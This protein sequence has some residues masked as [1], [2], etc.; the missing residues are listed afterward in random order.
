[1]I[2]NGP[3]EAAGPMRREGPVIRMRPTN[4]WAGC[5]A[6]ARPYACGLALIETHGAATATGFCQ[7]CPVREA[8]LAGALA[9]REPWGVW[10]GELISN[11]KILAN[12]RKRGRPPKARPVE[13]EVLV[14]ADLMTAQIA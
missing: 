12:K 11:G 14:D 13:A 9:R 2:A 7:A 6:V 4:R 5:P 3:W 10:G 8:C 1:M